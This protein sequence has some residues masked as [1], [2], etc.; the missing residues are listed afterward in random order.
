MSHTPHELTE[1]FPAEAAKIQTLKAKS[2]HFA[3]L[4]DDYHTVN[5]AVHRSEIRVDLLT[6]EH[7][8]RL[9]RERAHLKDEIWHYL[10]AH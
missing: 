6:N 4:V 10:K 7:E 1:E 2:P 9:R 5:R 3:K 8:E